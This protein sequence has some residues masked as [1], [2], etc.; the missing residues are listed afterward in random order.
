[1]NKDLSYLREF[2]LV[3]YLP[4]G[5][6]KFL[7]VVLGSKVIKDEGWQSKMFAY[8]GFDPEKLFKFMVNDLKKNKITV[9]A[10][11]TKIPKEYKDALHFIIK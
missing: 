3:S 1:M 6:A 7:F 9:V 5:P 8:E 11:F 10:P 4:F 2:L